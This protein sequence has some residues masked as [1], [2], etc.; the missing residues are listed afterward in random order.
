MPRPE[1]RLRPHVTV[2]TA[3]ERRLARA[4]P[5]RAAAPA[6]ATAAA[7]RTCSAARQ[8][9][10]A[11]SACGARSPRRSPRSPRR[12]AA[13]LPALRATSTPPATSSRGRWRGWSSG[14]A[15]T[16]RA[17]RVDA[18]R[19]RR[20]AAF[21]APARPPAGA[22]AVG[23]G[24]GAPARTRL[25]GTARRRHRPGAP[26]DAPAALGGG[27]PMVR[28]C[29]VLARRRAPGRRRARL[30]RHA[31]PL[32]G[33]R[34]AV[35]MLDLTAGELVHPRHTRAARRGEAVDGRS[36]ARSRVARVPRAAR[37][38]PA[39]RREAQPPP[40]SA[41]LRAATPRAVLLP[42]ADDAHPD[43]AAAGE[44]A[45]A[46]PRSSPAWRAGT[47]SSAQPQSAAA[48]AG[49][50]GTA[51]ARRARPRGRR[52]GGVR[53]K[54]AALA[55]YASQFVAGRWHGDAPVERRTSWPRSRV[56]TAPS[57]TRSAASSAE[58]FVGA[59]P[60]AG[61]RGGVA[62]RRTMTT[63]GSA[64]GP[65]PREGEEACGSA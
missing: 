36:G 46:A 47:A 64:P 10:A 60:A 34:T 31:G 18:G 13:E 16:A 32:G 57:A 41:A 29:D 40:W 65:A 11:S 42:H 43:H 49:L 39:R 37:R 2:V 61:R 24:A 30:R 53:A 20:L 5:R 52:D 45:R 1:W 23:A 8:A 9:A 21:A 14:L 62:G 54:R 55:A 27:R 33:R 50:P 19:W 22:G 7:A 35:G 38:R 48:A 26:R 17:R 6:A 58:G 56:A 12:P 44:L 4:A 15:A 59:R 63:R 3:A 25:A 28:L 51:A